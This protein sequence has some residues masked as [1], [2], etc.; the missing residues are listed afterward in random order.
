M[1]CHAER[2]VG[3]VRQEC[4]DHLLIYNES[5]ARVILNSYAEHFNEH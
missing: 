5:R 4:T 1:N 3:S 2:F